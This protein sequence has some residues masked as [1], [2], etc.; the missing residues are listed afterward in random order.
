MSIADINNKQ[1]EDFEKGKIEF[2]LCNPTKNGFPTKEIKLH[3]AFYDTSIYP[4]LKNINYNILKE[5][6]FGKNLW[7]D[8]PEYELSEKGKWKIIPLITFG[9]YINSERFPKSTEML[10]EIPNIVNAG[11][12]KFNGKTKL[13][14]HKGWGQLSNN[15][16]RCHLGID[17]PDGCFLYV[18]DPYGNYKMQQKNNKWIVFDDS[19]Y[20]S[21]INESEKERI[22]FIVD[23]KRPDYLHK[24]VS[25]VSDTEELNEFIKNHL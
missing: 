13:K 2:L 20:H 16:L 7:E 22:V 24:G 3:Q 17:V 18:I 23:I 10:K 9:K 12:S 19:L 5:E 25:D 1:V 6:L 8:W 11:F 15:V 14:L 4:C 21:A